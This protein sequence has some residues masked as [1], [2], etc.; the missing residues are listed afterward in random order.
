M[1]VTRRKTIGLALSGG[2]ARG[3]AHLGVLRVLERAKIPI[4]VV[5]GVSAGSVVGAL[6]SAGI[7]LEDMI[8]AMTDFSWLKIISLT[9]PI[10]GLVSFARLED[11]LKRWIGDVWFSDL[12][13]P[14]AVGTTDLLTG[15]PVTFTSGRVLPLV[16]ASCSI[17]GIVVPLDYGAYWLVDGGISCN[18]PSQAARALGADF[19]IGVDILKPYV[20]KAFGVPGVGSTALEIMIR[21]SGGGLADANVV[22]SPALDNKTYSRFSRAKEMMELGEYAAEA[23]LPVLRAELDHEA[24]PEPS[25]RQFSMEPV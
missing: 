2:G 20:R 9:W 13:K 14:F 15:R 6:Y 18:L 11:F 16:R 19:V 24:L 5:A 10:H 23:M 4:D 25:P 3:P 21:H 17:P 12:K 7:P 22:I 1:N 8:A